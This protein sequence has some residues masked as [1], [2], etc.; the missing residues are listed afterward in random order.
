MPDSF[1]DSGSNGLFFDDP[2]I[3]DC[4][5]PLSGFYCPTSLLNLS[6]T[7]AG[8]NGNS[9][10]VHF[11]VSNASTLSS[12]EN[13]AFN[14]LGANNGRMNSILA[15]PSFMDGRCSPQFREPRRPPDRVR[16]SPFEISVRALSVILTHKP[17]AWKI[18][19]WLL[20]V[21][22]APRR[23]STLALG[24]CIPASGALQQVA[25]HAQ[26]SDG[27]QQVRVA[28]DAP[29]PTTCAYRKFKL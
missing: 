8:Q 11:E 23:V 6:A 9:S 20:R 14:D 29:A 17:V 15:C 7:A 27:R 4:A 16:I 19:G 2:T 24:Q 10:P 12:S 13:F 26:I 5:S 28:L 3:P 22:S 25:A 18:Q 1:I 21:Y